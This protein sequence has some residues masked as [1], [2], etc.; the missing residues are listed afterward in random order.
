MSDHIILKKATSNDA[1]KIGEVFDLYR[2]FYKK[3]SDVE[4]CK[5][6]IKERLDNNEADIFFLE[7][8]NDCIGLVQLYTTFDSLELS[9]K[10]VLYDLYVKSEFRTQGLGK[11]L[12]S[13]A[14]EFAKKNKISGIELSTAKNNNNAQC[15][16]EGLGYERDED[17]YNYYLSVTN[18]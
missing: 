9:K 1:D 7:N 5:K 4:L 10:I 16:Y 3:V 12:M 18:D 15:L 14:L 8:N 6:Y 2:Q 13:A 17:F 11:K